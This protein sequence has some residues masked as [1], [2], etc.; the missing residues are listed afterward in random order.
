MPDYGTEE[1]IRRDEEEVRR[2]RKREA[3]EQR[4][5]EVS[6]FADRDRKKTIGELI[7]YPGAK[8]TK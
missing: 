1:D 3:E 4:D 7:G 6:R 2:R 5:R 8:K